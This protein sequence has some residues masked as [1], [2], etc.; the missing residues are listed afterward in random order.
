MQPG[1]VNADDALCRW[2]KQVARPIGRRSEMREASE[3]DLFVASRLA[4]V[5]ASAANLSI[6]RRRPGR[7]V[8]DG[9]RHDSLGPS[10]PFGLRHALWGLQDR[11]RPGGRSVGT[12]GR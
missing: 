7:H 11:G 6:C 2:T 3:A 5:A 10:S 8:V 12:A 9:D 1:P 4:D